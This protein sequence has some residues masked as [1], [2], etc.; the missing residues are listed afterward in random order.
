MSDDRKKLPAD[1]QAI[2][3]K[4]FHPSGTF[5]EFP[6]EDVETS[7]PAR[8]EKIVRMYPERLAVVAKGENV[9]YKELNCVANR[10]A[11]AVLERRGNGEEP[12]A[13]F[14]EHDMA[15]I[16]TILGVL[17]AGK[18]Y[19]P[20]DSSFPVAN[21]ASIMN[22]AQARLLVVKEQNFAWVK[23]IVPDDQD[24]LAINIDEPISSDPNPE[25]ALAPSRLASI[26]YTSGSTGKPKGV[27]KDHRGILH[28]IRAYTNDVHVS[29]HDG[30]TLLHSCATNASVRNLLGSLLNGATLYPFDLRSESVAALA[31]WLNREKIT[32][33][34]AAASLFRALTDVLSA[35]EHFDHLR[36]IQ[37]SSES[38]SAED[39]KRFKEHCTAQCIFANRLGTTET[40]TL[41]RW[42]IKHDDPDPDDLNVPAGFP[43]EGTE[44]LI[45]DDDH[46][47]VEVDAI[48][49]I[50]VKSRHL[51]LGYWQQPELTM[52]KFIPDPNGGEERLYFTGDLGRMTATGCLVHLGRKDFTTK[53][54]GQTVI[55]SQIEA[56][57]G[58]HPSIK[59]IAV[60]PVSRPDGDPQL[61]AY[62]VPNFAGAAT[63]K[64]LRQ[65]LR[66]KLPDYMVPSAFV[67][68]D[69]L[70]LTPAGKVDRS[71]LP[72][73]GPQRPE[74]EVLYVA[75]RT[76]T[77][78]ILAGI[79]ADT[80]HLESV[81][82][83]DNFFDL[84]GHSLA[85]SRVISRVIQTFKLD[86]PLQALFDVPTV[87]QM[88]EVVAR[89]Q[90]KSMS[91][92]ELERLLTEIEAMTEGEAQKQLGRQKADAGQ[93]A[94]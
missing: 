18:M 46:N 88:A 54:R 48:G 2:R 15:A 50:V 82:I 63:S 73:P 16:A 9:T 45:I 6:I 70:P 94:T 29:M 59:Q 93:K 51:A 71:K 77:E 43:T 39:V 49:E 53:L 40:D 36:L 14:L 60:V 74:S 90:G 86:L 87:A 57:L 24:V 55:L 30:L 65:Y 84:G 1:Q 72:A 64:G 20:L 69:E 11:R 10:I 61:V 31:N 66:R 25:F 3:D 28:N 26:L 83:H 33:F 85:A 56:A 8:F 91:N 34:H 38:I 22:D 7:I 52:A 62:A 21:L 5:V 4:C 92:E 17:K 47:P 68:L 13:V 78:Q 41:A 76:P 89:H 44:I 75:P 19:V 58:E 23:S 35:D 67:M 37:L 12:V 81:G 79:W 27:F 42:F 80:L 32:I